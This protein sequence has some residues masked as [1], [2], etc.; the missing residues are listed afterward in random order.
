MQKPA[1]PLSIYEDLSAFKLYYLDIGLLGPMVGVEPILVLIANT[2]FTEYK[3]GMTE[4][5]VLQQIR[6]AG[7]SPVYYHN[8]DDSRLEIDFVTQLDGHILPIE[9]KAE[10]N[11]R[12][13]S[14][15]KLLDGTPDMTAVRFSML[16]YREQGQLTN[17]PLYGAGLLSV[18]ASRRIAALSGMLPDDRRPV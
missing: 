7:I 13:N 2:V 16:P 6:S 5:F 11:V 4:Q 18:A 9:V 14:L 8:T 17:I 15:S 12:T 10:G 3:G 1:L